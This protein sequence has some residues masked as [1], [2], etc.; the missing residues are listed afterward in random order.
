MQRLQ[1]QRIQDAPAER[2]DKKGSWA[3]S[4]HSNRQGLWFVVPREVCSS[5]SLL[6][7]P[8][9]GSVIRKLAIESQEGSHPLEQLVKCVGVRAN[10]M[11]SVKEGVCNLQ[12]SKE[13]GQRSDEFAGIALQG[14]ARG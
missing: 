10:I 11:K 2:C 5:S 9:G 12:A 3:P 4:S 8:I 13:R 7:H 1:K 6:Q 14:S